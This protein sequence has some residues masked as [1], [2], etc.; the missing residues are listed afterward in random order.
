MAANRNGASLVAFLRTVVTNLLRHG[1][2]SSLHAGK[3]AESNELMATVALGIIR[4][5]IAVIALL[6]VMGLD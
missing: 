2:N 3:Q 4:V 5:Q 6:N 1:S